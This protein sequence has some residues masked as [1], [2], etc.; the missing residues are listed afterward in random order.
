MHYNNNMKNNHKAVNNPYYKCFDYYLLQ[1]IGRYVN[2]CQLEDY[3]SDFIDK[4]ISINPNI[5]QRTFDTALLMFVNSA[6]NK[7]VNE[8]VIKY[9]NL[10]TE[11][12]ATILIKR[13]LAKILCEGEAARIIKMYK[14]DKTCPMLEDQYD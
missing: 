14:I 8:L 1:K 7:L 2:R 13:V 10:S 3:F 9:S 4:G 5:S 6:Y 12:S 11:C